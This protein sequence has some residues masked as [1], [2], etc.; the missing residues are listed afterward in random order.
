MANTPSFD[1]ARRDCGPRAALLDA[2]TSRVFD[3]RAALQLDGQRRRSARA[4]L[5]AARPRES[6]CRRR[7]RTFSKD[8]ARQ[9]HRGGHET[10]PLPA[11]GARCAACL[12]ASIA[13]A[14]K[15]AC[16]RHAAKL[17]TPYGVGFRLSLCVNASML[18]AAGRDLSSICACVSGLI[19][20]GTCRT[21]A[22]AI[23]RVQ[24]S[25]L[26]SCT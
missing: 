22:R 6:G 13:A 7:R 12:R 16:S 3:A 21:N 1:D 8:R 20:I 25:V 5:L 11:R 10:V 14:K 17:I 9:F 15:R 23:V 24:I 19:V 26:D 4:G 18:R 2:C